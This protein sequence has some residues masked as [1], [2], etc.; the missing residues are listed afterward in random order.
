VVT[1]LSSVQIPTFLFFSVTNATYQEG[2]GIQEPVIRRQQRRQQHQQQ[3]QQC[4]RPRPTSLCHAYSSASSPCFCHSPLS[5]SAPPVPRNSP[6]PLILHS[7][8]SQHYRSAIL[9]FHPSP[10][11]KLPCRRSHILGARFRRMLP[12]LAT[13]IGNFCPISICLVAW[14]SFC[15]SSNDAANSTMLGK[16]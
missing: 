4:T 3:H 10:K 16:I 2:V 6:Q 15:P 14:L 5:A 13:A 7:S 1:S 9:A 11:P 12:S 8:A